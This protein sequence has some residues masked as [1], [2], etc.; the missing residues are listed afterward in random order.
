MYSLSLP[1]LSMT[2]WFC[3]SVH[4]WYTNF[5]S[6]ELLNELTH[7]PEEQNVQNYYQFTD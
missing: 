6:E 5:S 4:C 2:H 3:H 7:E 1:E